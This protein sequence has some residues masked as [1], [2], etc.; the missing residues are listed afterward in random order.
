MTGA[1]IT[2]D[3]RGFCSGRSPCG[4]SF[5]LFV[6][7]KTATPDEIVVVPQP[8]MVYHGLRKKRRRK[9]KKADSKEATDTVCFIA[10]QIRQNN[11]NDTSSTDNSEAHRANAMM[12]LP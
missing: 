12:R 3:R 4:V 6:S 5:L 9:E 8:N 11:N 2:H 10:S 7:C 1:R